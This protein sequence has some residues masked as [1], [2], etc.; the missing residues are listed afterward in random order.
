[1][2]HTNPK[3]IEAHYRAMQIGMR[4]VFHELGLAVDDRQL[5]LSGFALN[6]VPAFPVV[7]P[8]RPLC[9]GDQIAAAAPD[10]M[11][12]RLADLVARRHQIVEMIA[13]AVSRNVI[14]STRTCLPRM[15]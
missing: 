2:A 5:F 14:S 15:R 7:V 10:E 4:G 1:V 13:A 9:R 8:D 11:T 12:R 6:L 3:P